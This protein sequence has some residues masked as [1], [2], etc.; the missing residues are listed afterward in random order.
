MDI[1]RYIAKNQPTWNRLDELTRRAQSN[2][3]GLAT[4]EL[5]ELVQ[6]Y[7]RTSSHLSYVRTYLRDPSLISRLTR[8]V[9]TANGVIYGKR[10]RTIKPF[11][12]FFRYSFPGAVY[13]MRRFVVFSAVA[14]FGTAAVFAVWLVNDPKALDASAPPKE[15]QAYVQERFEQYYSDQPS[16]VF[17][18]EVTTNNIRVSF[19]AYGFGAVS[20]G[21]GALYMLFQ[22]GAMLG[23]V[24]AWMITTGD[25]ARFFGFIIPHGALELSAIIIAAGA[26][27]RI[28]WT[29]IAPGD[30]TRS[31]AFRE[32]GSRS[33]AVII[34]LMTMFLA[35]GLIEGFITGSGIPIGLRVGIGVMLWFAYVTYLLVQGRAAAARGV[36]GLLGER[37][38]RWEDDPKTFT[39]AP[40]SGSE[41]GLPTHEASSRVGL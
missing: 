26:G 39:A 32:E 18:T 21:L 1:D 28:G 31:D 36:T 6:L 23:I 25:T 20:G 35:A 11:L 10:P 30:R 14:F 34:G 9:A 16:P 13:H 41:L 8:Q 2:V 19:V 37:P 3:G 27:L 29:A 24:S 15:R 5:E 22:N 4:T 38:K 12:D 40:E 17:F 7:Q 33:I